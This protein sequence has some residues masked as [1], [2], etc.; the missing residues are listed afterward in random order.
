MNWNDL[1]SYD[2][3]T[4][5]LIW[6]RREGTPKMVSNFNANYANKPAGVKAY[7]NHG[8]FAVFA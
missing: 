5:A 6:K 1:F 3:D 8:E 4:G 2:A 7:A